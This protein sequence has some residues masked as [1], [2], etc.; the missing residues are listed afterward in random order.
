MESARPAARPSN[1]LRWIATSLLTLFLAACATNNLV[2]TGP[3]GNP[4]VDPDS[5]SKRQYS[6]E[7]FTHTE[8]S[9]VLSFEVAGYTSDEARL[10]FNPYLS[11]PVAA[12][13]RE[14]A[15]AHPKA[16]THSVGG[17]EKIDAW[18]DP[19]RSTPQ[20]PVLVHAPDQGWYL[21]EPHLLQK[22]AEG[23][24]FVECPAKVKGAKCIRHRNMAGR[25]VEIA[26]TD[27][28]LQHWADADVALRTAL[29]SVL[30]P[31]MP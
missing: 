21:V 3:D 5:I 19:A 27:T 13:L 12:A 6:Q 16:V 7:G 28:D 17:L 2:E 22:D 9:A 18:T 26:M 30:S 25:S 1:R 29:L 4:C 20:Q 10:S 31:C 14:Y 15:K 23:G 11:D 24:F 8:T